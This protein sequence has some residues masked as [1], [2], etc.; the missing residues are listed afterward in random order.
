MAPCR[1][2]GRAL[3]ELELSIE[4]LFACSA[5]SAHDVNCCQLLDFG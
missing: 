1:K 4:A 2:A 5:H 3:S